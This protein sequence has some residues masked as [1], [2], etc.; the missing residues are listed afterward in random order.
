MPITNANNQNEISSLSNTVYYISNYGVNSLD[1]MFAIINSNNF[2]V[3][4]SVS[5]E[6]FN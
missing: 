2:L 3:L 6:K 5:K 4:S 1:D